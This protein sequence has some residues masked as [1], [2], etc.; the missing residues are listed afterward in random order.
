METTYKLLL[1]LLL[2]FVVAMIGSKVHLFLNAKIQSSESGWSLLGYILLLFAAYALLFLG[3][4]AALIKV[5]DFLV[6]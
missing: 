1:F 3:S 2:L 6:G 5:Y 4:L